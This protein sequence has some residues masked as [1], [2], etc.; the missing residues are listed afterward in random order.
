MVGAI[1]QEQEQEQ[2]W[3]WDQ[4]E[5]RLVRAPWRWGFAARSWMLVQNGEAVEL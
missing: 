3:G 5:D 2:E 4:V 1:E